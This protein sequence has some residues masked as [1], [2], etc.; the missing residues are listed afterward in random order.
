MPN[1][2]LLIDKSILQ[3][4]IFLRPTGDR[5]RCLE[6]YREHSDF[7]VH[8]KCPRS[9]NFRSSNCRSERPDA[10]SKMRISYRFNGW[11]TNRIL[12]LCLSQKTSQF[13]YR[14]WLH[15]NL[16]A[17]NSEKTACMLFGVFIRSQFQPYTGQSWLFTTSL[18]HHPYKFEIQVVSHPLHQQPFIMNAFYR[19]C[20]LSWKPSIVKAATFDQTRKM[21]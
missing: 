6:Q 9:S 4:P 8:E 13:L 1:F 15:L 12:I 11:A 14:I 2:E 16:L 7:L 18:Q 17:G 3:L 5:W 10:I 20:L 19:E 21:Q